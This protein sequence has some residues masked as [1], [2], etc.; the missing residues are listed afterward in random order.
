MSY[1]ILVG[2]DNSLTTTRKT[3]IMQRSKLVDNL[4]FLA[5][6]IYKGQDMSQYTVYLEYILPCSKKYCIEILKL[7][8]EMYEDH[9]KYLLPF[10][11]NLTSESGEIEVQLSFVKVDLDEN[12]KCI[13]RV[14]KT[15]T[16][17]INIIP[18]S[19]WSDIIPDEALTAIDRRIMET[20]AQI[21]ALNDISKTLNDEKADNI[22][23]KDGVLQL[24]ANKKEIGNAVNLNS[25]DCGE[26]GIPVVDFSNSTDFVTP[27]DS[28]N[29]DMTNNVIEF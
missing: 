28:I 1:V 16:C 19:A 24:I 4:C 12:G 2:E 8:D 13:Q 6:P 10:D 17:K 27:D 29:S 23:Y 22:S 7:S 3:R 15:S 5:Y 14:R 9:L 18:I 21:K 25:C 20:D 26:D 11:T